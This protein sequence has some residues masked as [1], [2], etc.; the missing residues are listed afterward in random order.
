MERYVPND[1]TARL[2]HP[3]TNGTGCRDEWTEVKCAAARQMGRITI[4]AVDS[5]GQSFTPIEIGV[6]ALPDDHRHPGFTQTKLTRSAGRADLG[7]LVL[8]ASIGLV[9]HVRDRLKRFN[10]PRSSF[11]ERRR[12]T[13]LIVR[14]RLEE[15]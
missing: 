10:S 6:Q 13:Q 9:A 14:S 15:R 3:C 2:R 7:Q 1:V 12:S 4:K 8:G 5:L 11:L